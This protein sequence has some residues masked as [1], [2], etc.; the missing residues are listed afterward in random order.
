MAVTEEATQAELSRT[1]SHLERALAEKTDL[2]IGALYHIAVR[3]I[4]S[5]ARIT[6]IVSD[7]KQFADDLG[8]KMERELEE[9]T[10]I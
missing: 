10:L 1:L 9:V 8:L 3:K 6:K 4:D 2:A 5:Q 7:L